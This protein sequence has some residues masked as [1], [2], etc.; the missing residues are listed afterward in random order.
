MTR[1]R[2]VAAAVCCAVASSL[3][4]PS[5]A[6]ADEQSSVELGRSFGRGIL[7]FR[8]PW[9]CEMPLLSA[10]CE[11]DVRAIVGDR[12]DRIA[13]DLPGSG[14]RPFSGLNDFI[15]HGNRDGYDRALVYV[16][17]AIATPEMWAKSPTD[18]ALF[19]V[20]ATQ[21][22]IPASVDTISRVFASSPARDLQAHAKSGDL[23]GAD[24]TMVQ[25]IGFENPTAL[26]DMNASPQTLVAASLTRFPESPLATYRYDRPNAYALF[27]VAGAWVAE[28]IDNSPWVGQSDVDTFVTAWANQAVV[29]APSAAP[30]RST[31]LSILHKTPYDHDR[32][33][34]ASVDLET[35]VFAALPIEKKRQIFFGVVSAQLA[36]NAAVLRNQDSARLYLRVLAD[37][38]EAD[39][40]SPDVA[41]L[42]ATASTVDSK[43]WA[44][45]FALGRELSLAIL[46]AGNPP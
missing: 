38:G 8:D 44:S 22:A 40:V 25:A 4:F 19:D 9:V 41:R 14:P 11:A 13:K 35:A 23:S 45:Q 43:D 18:A 21:V 27:G 30:A 42:R 46:T 36:Y 1:F 24:R 17:T 16:N 3:L 15:E 2:K 34:K 26:I 32:V 20:G 31:F 28:F 12:G 6:A 5:L 10:R 29:F 39:P 33:L 7:I 37:I